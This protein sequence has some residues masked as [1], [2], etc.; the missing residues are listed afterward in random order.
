MSSH[1]AEASKTILVLV[2]SFSGLITGKCGKDHFDVDCS[3]FGTF[4]TY[5]FATKRSIMSLYACAISG[6]FWSLF[7]YSEAVAVPY[8]SY[9]GDLA[10]F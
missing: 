6:D 1:V 3:L 9:L 4:L 7:R 8:G 10:C 5:L 2:L